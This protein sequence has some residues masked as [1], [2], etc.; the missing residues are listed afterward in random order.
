MRRIDKVK[1]ARLWRDTTL[2][3][4]EIGFE[5]GMT[6][7][8]TYKAAGRIGLGPR[9]RP[10]GGYRT[11]GVPDPTP[12]EIAQR[13]AE[14]RARSLERMQSMD[15]HQSDYIPGIRVVSA[16]PHGRT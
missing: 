5:M 16:V 12:E 8:A 13:A 9:P 3:T 7:G 11:R 15:Y 14:I 1:L 6:S 4:E 10:P 2:T